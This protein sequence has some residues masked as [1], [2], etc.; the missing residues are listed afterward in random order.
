MRLNFNVNPGIRGI[1]SIMD[2][3]KKQIPGIEMEPFSQVSLIINFD[4][5]HLLTVI[6][7]LN[8][9]ALFYTEVKP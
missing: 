5:G 6:D 3:F 7:I 9:L 8:G 4:E 2:T 1:S